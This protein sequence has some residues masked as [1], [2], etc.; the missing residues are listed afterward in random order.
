VSAA[1]LPGLADRFVN[2]PAG[3]RIRDLRA[4]VDFAAA[5]PASVRLEVIEVDDDPRGLVAWQLDTNALEVLLVRA[6]A[7]LGETT[8]GRHLLGLMRDRAVAAG[9]SAIRIVDSRPSS[10]VG[11]S[12]RDEGFASDGEVV[13]GHAFAGKGMLDELHERARAAASPL[14]GGSL[15]A[16]GSGGLVERAAEAERWFA[17]FRVIG[18]GIPT[19]VV[20]IQHGWATDLVDVGLA[21]DQ[22]LPRPW[23]LGLRRELVYYRSPR[24]PTT[25]PVP[26]RLVWYVSGSALGAGT[27][28]AVSHL[29]EVAI[30]AHERL[31]HRFRPLGVYSKADVAAC[32]DG[33]GRAMALRF[34]STERLA[35]PIPLDAY[36]EL[37]SGDPKSRSVVMQSIR[38]L[39]EQMF[40]RLLEMGADSGG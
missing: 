33:R 35:R 31:F 7:G 39:D 9:A 16:V 13:V 12:F 6:T 40:A 37:V 22:L 11:R 27:I 30:D 34:S 18:A 29:T 5:R 28:R 4:A 14:A 15:F 19:F 38:P 10:T 2:H 26:A 17:P 1:A 3:E 23:G 8:I 20:P 32:A 24:N 36:R 21:Q 25:L